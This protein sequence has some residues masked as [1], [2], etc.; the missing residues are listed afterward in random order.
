MPNFF[1]RNNS[2]GK[3]LGCFPSRRSIYSVGMMPRKFN[4]PTAFLAL[5]IPYKKWPLIVPIS[6]NRLPPL[7]TWTSPHPHP[8]LPTPPLPLSANPPAV[9]PP[10]PANYTNAAPLPPLPT[11]HLQKTAP[12][13][14]LLPPSLHR[15]HSRPLSLSSTRLYQTQTILHCPILR[16][17]CCRLPHHCS[18]NPFPLCPLHPHP[19]FLGNPQ[20][21]PPLRR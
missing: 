21:H 15:W 7:F 9:L 5:K 14:P 11:F 19:Y 4:I 12:P 17:L 3:K 18:R 2:L 8:Y 13:A 10:P 1:L 6:Q 20:P 16:R